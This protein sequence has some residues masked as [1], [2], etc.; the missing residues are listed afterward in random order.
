M[1]FDDLALVAVMALSGCLLVWLVW[2]RHAPLRFDVDAP[3]SADGKPFGANAPDS[4][5]LDRVGELVT[6][7]MH[8]K[9]G[10]QQLPS[11]PSGVPG[12]DGVFVRKAG[13]GRQ[14][15][16]RI[17]ETKCVRDGEARSHYDATPM[18]DA[19]V[20]ERLERLKS[21]TFDGLPALD[22][23]AIDTI[24]RAIRRGSVHVTKHF[25][26][27]MLPTGKTM[28]YSVGRDGQLIDSR[29]A[30]VKRTDGEQH[31][32]MLQALAIGLTRLDGTDLFALAPGGA[33]A[34]SARL[35]PNAAPA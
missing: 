28:V 27:H 18:S 14:F 16:V 1:Q 30:R 23:E 17:V 13:R 7:L 25:Y 32:L 6:A 20:I 8:A 19:N 11:Q 2:A 3:S 35:A 21:A 4:S 9:D 22:G 10:W 24:V 12:L 29:A 34:H 31:R 33:N 15:E 26:A 5:S